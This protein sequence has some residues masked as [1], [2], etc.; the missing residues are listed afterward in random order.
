MFSISLNFFYL[1][2]VYFTKHSQ[3][4]VLMLCNLINWRSYANEGENVNKYPSILQF[5]LRCFS[6]GKS[7]IRLLA[8]CIRFLS[9]ERNEKLINKG[10]CHYT[11]R[12]SMRFF[13][14]TF[15]MA[16]SLYMLFEEIMAAHVELNDNSDD[17]A[18][19]LRLAG[20]PRRII[21]IRTTK[22]YEIIVLS[23][24]PDDFRSHFR[25]KRETIEVIVH[26]LAEYDD[27][28][29][30]MEDANPWNCENKCY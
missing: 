15:E 6:L 21:H 14:P 2:E 13:P 7:D 10:L 28:P 12:H 1:K 23:Y 17:G 24:M 22:F 27:L 30:V 3:Y 11:T 20:S 9:D 19:L 4:T 18:V 26:L 25:M 29:I 5:D 8:K 16:A